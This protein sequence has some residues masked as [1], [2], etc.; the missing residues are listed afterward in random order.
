MKNSETKD[1]VAYEYMSLRVKQDKEPLYI[2]CYEN[3]GWIFINNSALVDKE[4]YFINNIGFNNK[5]VN[6]RFKRDR[7]IANKVKLMSLQR[8]LESALKMVEKLENA[9]SSYAIVWAMTIGF[10]GTIFLAISVFAITASNPYYF[11]SIL[12]GIPGLVGWVLPY[13]VYVNKIREKE[14]E[15]IELIEEQ[16]N[17][18][19][20]SCEQAKKLIVG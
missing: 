7:R 1:F 5:V 12:T 2:D 14:L 6:L 19:Y 11:L 3:L 17:I 9:P 8:K 20:D 13:F 4:D 10:I 18:I 16:Y 15:N